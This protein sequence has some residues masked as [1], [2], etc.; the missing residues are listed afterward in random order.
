V[1]GVFTTH[2]RSPALLDERV[3]TL[4]QKVA[5]LLSRLDAQG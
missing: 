5:E 1:K 3:A 2:L 4:E